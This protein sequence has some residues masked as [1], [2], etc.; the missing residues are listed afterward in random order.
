MSLITCVSRAELQKT[1]L[2]SRLQSSKVW[3]FPLQQW[4]DAVDFMDV[5]RGIMIAKNR[6][7]EL[8]NDPQFLQV[9]PYLM[10]VD[11]DGKYLSY[12]RQ[13][14]EER[15]HKQTSVGIG[16]HVL[17]DT[18]DLSSLKASLL[19]EMKREAQ[20]EL[21]QSA[22]DGIDWSTLECVALIQ[23]DETMVG[24]VHLGFL[25]R[26]GINSSG[27]TIHS[28]EC[29]G[30]VP[31]T[32]Q[33][34]LETQLEEWS[35]IAMQA[36][37]HRDRLQ[38]VVKSQVNTFTGTRPANSVGAY[39]VAERDLAMQAAAIIEESSYGMA[40]GMWPAATKLLE[41]TDEGYEDS[42]IDTL[43]A[44]QRLLFLAVEKD[45]STGTFIGDLVKTGFFEV[46]VEGRLGLLSHIG[47]NMLGHVWLSVR[48]YSY[49]GH[50]PAAQYE[51][52]YHSA[53]NALRQYLGSLDPSNAAIDFLVSNARREKIDRA[54][55]L[56]LVGEAYDK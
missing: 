47:L 53:A 1:I 33:E 36:I 6:S 44:I 39:Q 30:I 48:Q 14:Q 34:L 17:L 50:D 23:S 22:Y 12:V 7:D 52:V 18:D 54:T 4:P 8:E 15:L 55:L 37:S 19:E 51:K 38:T 32:T 41:L 5:L 56:R 11:N 49:A 45:E 40:T 10:L 13:G 25:Y 16:G 35:E 9:I 26:V 20:E 2:Y 31:R 24:R 21:G 46:S 3:M 42:V 28:E 29:G 27:V 43:T